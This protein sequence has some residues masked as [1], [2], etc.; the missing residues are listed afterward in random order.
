[1]IMNDNFEKFFESLI[2]GRLK[3]SEKNYEKII[4]SE[5]MDSEKKR[6]YIK[7]LE[8]LLFTLKSNDDRYLYFA[9]ESF[10]DDTLHKLEKEFSDHINNPLRSEYDRGYFSA[11]VDYIK[12]LKKR[13]PK[14][15]VKDSD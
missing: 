3:E 12:I 2:Q 10:D 1:M 7:A 9:K 4:I 6:G 5:G 8:G 11:L 13:P 15:Q 14:E